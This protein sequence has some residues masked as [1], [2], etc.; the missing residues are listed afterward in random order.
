[1]RRL[2]S[3]R[4]R[5]PCLSS[6]HVLPVLH[7]RLHI[8]A[9]AL[10][11]QK[12][13]SNIRPTDVTF[14]PH[15]VEHDKEPNS[16]TSTTDEHGV[17]TITINRPHRRN[18]IDGPTGI[19]LTNAFL[20]FEKDPHAKVCVFYGQG[21]NFCAGFDLHEVAKFK[22]EGDKEYRGARLDEPV[23][24]QNS[25]G[26]IG[27]SRMQIKKPV[28]S[29]VAGYCVAGGLELSLLGDMRVVEE[30]AVFGV[31]CRRF[32]VPLIDGGVSSKSSRLLFSASVY[33]FTD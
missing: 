28:I 21:G 5:Y 8:S 18:A 1:M 6:R 9:P 15:R 33:N 14:G 4:L 11:Q 10:Q 30:D 16:V 13:Q 7:H 26:P 22:G 27:P 32:G 12:Q 2:S 31:F 29:A 25:L 17:T 24:G 19:K 23:K 3:L 20:A